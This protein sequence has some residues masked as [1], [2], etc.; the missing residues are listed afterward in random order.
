MLKIPQ[1]FVKSLEIQLK[2]LRKNKPNNVISKALWNRKVDI[3]DKSIKLFK[4][5]KFS[6]LLDKRVKGL[7]KEYPIIDYIKQLKKKK[8][9]YN[10]LDK[11][12]EQIKQIRKKITVVRQTNQKRKLQKM[13]SSILQKNKDLKK[14]ILYISYLPVMM[15]DKN[16]KLKYEKEK[17][18][19]SR[20]QT[21]KISNKSY[22]PTVRKITSGSYIPIPRF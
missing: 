7:T 22:L 5:G 9:L 15:R 12:M 19:A 16:F 4:S 18:K 6:Q 21:K 1:S 10:K 2:A 8:V 11:N 14:K 20:L 17:I 3:L 13:I